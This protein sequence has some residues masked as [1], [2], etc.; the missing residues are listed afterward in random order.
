MHTSVHRYPVHEH[1]RIVS[2]THRLITIHDNW[3]PALDARPGSC[4]C[5]ALFKLVRAPRQKGRAA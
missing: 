2:I 3:C 4:A 1:A 5:D